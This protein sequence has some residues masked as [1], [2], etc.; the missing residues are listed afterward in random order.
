MD[1]KKHRWHYIALILACL[2]ASLIVSDLI[3][4]TDITDHFWPFMFAPIAI[5]IL[6]IGIALRW[7]YREDH[8]K[9]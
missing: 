7:A 1:I 9:Q 4:Y 8:D 2:F 3:E 6:G 5:N